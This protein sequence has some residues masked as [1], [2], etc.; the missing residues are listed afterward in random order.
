[1]NRNTECG[2][3]S[4]PTQCKEA[5]KGRRLHLFCVTFSCLLKLG[6]IQQFL[7]APEFLDKDSSMYVRYEAKFT[8]NKAQ[9]SIYLDGGTSC[10]STV[11][12]RSAVLNLL[13]LRMSFS[14]YLCELIENIASMQLFSP[15]KYESSGFLLS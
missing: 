4:G 3:L 8:V 6:E 1:M 12:I 2:A 5:L 13:N 9:F 7:R 11:H 10:F 14:W 15:D